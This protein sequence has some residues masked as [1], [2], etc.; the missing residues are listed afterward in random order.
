MNDKKLFAHVFLYIINKD[1]FI[2]KKGWLMEKEILNPQCQFLIYFV[3]LLEQI[4]LYQNIPFI[5]LSE[6]RIKIS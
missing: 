5:H 6:Q 4:F 1:L 3:I 2:K